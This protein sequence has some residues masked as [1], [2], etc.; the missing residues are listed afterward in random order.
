M[1]QN[2]PLFK[3]RLLALVPGVVH[4]VLFGIA[5]VRD[6]HTLLSKIE[7]SCVGLMAS[8]FLASCVVIPVP[9][10]QVDLEGR[11]FTDSDLEFV[12]PGATARSEVIGHLGSPTLW[13]ASQRILVYGLRRVETGAL[14][15]IGAG[16]TGA[17]GLVEGETKE[18]VFLVFDDNDVATNWGRAPVAHCE[19]WLRAA[20]EW[21]ASKKLDIR[22]AHGRFVE[23][24]PTADQ[25]LI[26]FY[27]PRDYQYYLPFGPPAKKVALGVADYAEISH[28]DM[29]VGQ[30]RWKSYLLVRVAPGTHTFMVNPDTDCVVNPEYYRSA[31]IQLSITPESVTFLE[32]G[33]QAGRG[34]IN[35]IL[36]NRTRSEA[37][38]VIENLR[39]SW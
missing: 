30:I 34:T 16:L 4:A 38:S 21:A 26:Y 27:R 19:T 28:D 32:L 12:R 3:D 37:I 5:H 20:T 13:L 15:F 33:I 31:S 14:W 8:I 9:V 6:N 35:P 22:Q 2:L 36:V 24:P 39:E 17:G 18:A 10:E 1:F 23:E 7:K 25:S 29:L 11:R